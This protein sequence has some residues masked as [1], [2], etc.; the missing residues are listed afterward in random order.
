MRYK[1]AADVGMGFNSAAA[2][3]GEALPRDRLDD[4]I[5]W[6]VSIACAPNPG[7]VNERPER[8]KSGPSSTPDNDAAQAIRRGFAP[9]CGC[10]KAGARGHGPRQTPALARMTTEMPR[11]GRRVSALR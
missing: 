10:R 3:E 6:P 4:L 2:S 7:D 9:W 1:H 5:G 8:G 11:A